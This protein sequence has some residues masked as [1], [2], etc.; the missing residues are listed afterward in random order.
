M[1]Y[2]FTR[3]KKSSAAII[4]GKNTITHESAVYP[5]LQKKFNIQV[6]N[7]INRS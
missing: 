5:A 3:F 1:I 7:A 6:H 4:N 2:F